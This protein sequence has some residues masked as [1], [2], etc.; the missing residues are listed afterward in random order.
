MIIKLQTT[1]LSFSNL[2][3]NGDQPQAIM[4]SWW[5]ISRVEKRQSLNGGDWYREGALP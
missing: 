5:I 3:A 2:P 4:S 1:N